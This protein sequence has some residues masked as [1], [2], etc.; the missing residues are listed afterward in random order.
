[1]SQSVS[2]CVNV[3]TCPPACRHAASSTCFVLFIM[4]L[5]ICSDITCVILTSLQKDHA[6]KDSISSEWESLVCESDMMVYYR[7]FALQGS[8]A[9]GHLL[10]CTWRQRDFI[11]RIT[12]HSILLLFMVVLFIVMFVDNCWIEYISSVFSRLHFILVAALL[13]SFSFD[14]DC[15]WTGWSV[16]GKGV[17]DIALN[18]LS[19]P[20]S[21]GEV[22]CEFKPFLWILVADAVA[23]FIHG[24]VFV[25]LTKYS[26]P[27]ESNQGNDGRNW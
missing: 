6:A 25:M 18:S 22:E 7:P 14:F 23:L 10:Y 21:A 24:C 20:P 3:M 4:F 8:Y 11:L 15:F 17:L 9:E 12:V 27:W 13:V 16:C 19:S 5:A 2:F 1:M 26:N